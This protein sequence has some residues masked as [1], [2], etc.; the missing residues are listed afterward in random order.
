MVNHAVCVHRETVGFRISK[1]LL[2]LA[3]WLMM[4]RW[5]FD[6]VSKSKTEK[7]SPFWTISEGG[8]R[9][10]ALKKKKKKRNMK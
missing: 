9:T 10:W 3:L 1:W 2:P 5:F 7:M 4:G 6:I 8:N